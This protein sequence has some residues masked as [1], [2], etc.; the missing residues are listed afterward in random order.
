MSDLQKSGVSVE[1]KTGKCPAANEK[2]NQKPDEKQASNFTAEAFNK[3][4]LAV[5]RVQNE[6][7]LT[8]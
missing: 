5:S 8:K 7:W 1:P 4:I 3:N 6:Q 2:S